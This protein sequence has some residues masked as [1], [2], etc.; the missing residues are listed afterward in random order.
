MA[1]CNQDFTNSISEQALTFWIL[2]GQAK[3]IKENPFDTLL[4]HRLEQIGNCKFEEE[5]TVYDLSQEPNK[6]F[7]PRA[8]L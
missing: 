6:F 8:P 5:T 1:W 3:S 7:H 2:L 4:Q